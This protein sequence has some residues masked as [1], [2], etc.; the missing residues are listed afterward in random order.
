M[1]IDSYSAD[2]TFVSIPRVFQ[3][4]ER[5]GPFD[6]CLLCERN[7]LVPHSSADAPTYFV[8]RIFR[9]SE[10]IV[11]YALCLV[12]DDGVRSELSKESM[13]RIDVF[14]QE[15]VDFE[16][17]FR[18]MQ[19]RPDGDQVEAW[20]AECIV[21]KRKVED[22]H[23][24]QILAICRGDQLALGT[25]MML[26]GQAIEMVMPLLSQKTRDWLDEFTSTNFGMP[27]E[28]CDAPDFCPILV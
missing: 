22:C 26:S 6:K 27:P 8:E 12:C 16:R 25:S 7:L 17:R 5:E 19:Q 2:S 3:S 15:H 24:R 28:F 20:L 1:S 4:L 9:G 14:F 13:H 23:D 18:D 11:E 21:T 10:P